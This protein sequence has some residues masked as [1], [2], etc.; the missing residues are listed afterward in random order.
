MLILLERQERLWCSHQEYT[1]SETG[2]L[3]RKNIYFITFIYL[4][5]QEVRKK[6]MRQ[7]NSSENIK[8][9]QDYKIF[10]NQYH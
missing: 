6:G 10:Y 1:S 3:P 8:I 5:C 9:I 7:K 2:S 4:R